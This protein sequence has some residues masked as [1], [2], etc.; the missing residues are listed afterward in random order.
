V[1][2]LVLG[3][4]LAAV[5]QATAFP[6]LVAGTVRLELP[7]LLVVA[8]AILRGW[9]EGLLAGLIGGFLVDVTSAG[10]F[11]L[12]VIGLGTVGLLMGLV[13]M[14]LAR[15]SP[16]LPLLAAAGGSLVAFTLDVFGLQAAGWVVPWE[17]A[18]LLR[19]VPTALLSALGMAVLFPAV[20]ALE[21]LTTREVVGER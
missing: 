7:L 15:V 2:I 19:E 18:L 9:E 20:R 13:A 3:L 21:A 10:P 12:N 8:W 17:Q 6:G 14:R 5:V 1:L 4:L 11:G 16:L